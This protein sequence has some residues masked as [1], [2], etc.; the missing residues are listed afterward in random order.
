MAALG[1]VRGQHFAARVALMAEVSGGHHQRRQFAVRARCRLEADAG[2][3]G[4]FRQ[5]LLQLVE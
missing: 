3:A 1:R 2:Q 4:Y 5:I